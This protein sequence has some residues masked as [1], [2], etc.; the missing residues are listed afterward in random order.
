MIR[1]SK[2]LLSPV[3]AFVIFF[4]LWE[5]IGIFGLLQDSILPRPSTVFFM[6]VKHRELL[7]HHTLVTLSEAFIGFGLACVVAFILG[8]LMDYLTPLKNALHPF[9]VISQTI[10]IITVAPLFI[11][12]F[13]YGWMPKVMVVVMVCFFPI[14][15]NFLHGMDH[16]DQDMITL[17]KLMK[18]KKQ[19]Q[20]WLVKLPHALPFIFSGLKISAS[21]AIMGAVIGEW[22]GAKEGLGEYMRRSMKAFAVEQTFASIVI[23][24]VISLV[25]IWLIHMIEMAVMPWRKNENTE[26]I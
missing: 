14:L 7:W 17:L 25:W 8:M 2:K 6:L 20:F 23:I 1:L 4:G 19:D 18:A 16:V 26:E 15:I 9:L 22:L 24:S 21:Y 3:L 10:P 5:C 11:I 13:G 12:W